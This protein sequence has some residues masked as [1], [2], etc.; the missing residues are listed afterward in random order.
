[1]GF[2]TTDG[3]M[4]HLRNDK[5]IRIAGSL[6]KRQLSNIGYFHG[7]KGYRF[8]KRASNPIP[9]DSFKDIYNTVQFD[10]KIKSIIYPELMFIETA[11]K[12]RSIESIV[13]S[14]NSEDIQVILDK[15]I[16]SYKNSPA[17]ISTKLKREK[18][19]AKME[20]QSTIQRIILDAYRHNNPQITHFID[21]PSR[22]GVPLWALV[23][24]MTLGN[25]GKL[26]SCLTFNVRK[27]ISIKMNMRSSMD[28]NCEFLYKF[29]WLLKDL[30]NAVAHNSPVF[31]TRFR[32][33]DPSRA[34]KGYLASQTH[35]PF[36]KFDNIGDYIILI[37]F[38]L[39]ILGSSKTHIKSFLRS[40]KSACQLYEKSVAHNV[41]YRV[42]PH[43][44]YSR[45][46]IVAKNI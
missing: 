5:A 26:L 42:L 35:L 15:L 41:S 33:F 45:I 18:Q 6:E 40:Y 31:D 2:K 12:S 23:E 44:I 32:K 19:Q 17:N 39:K 4:R 10:S 30:R 46:S 43:G 37:A 36:V 8:F 1:M 25:F 13:L 3:L 21:S 14:A 27:E 38:I 29:V 24:V 28:T 11:I 20:L 7:Y 34:M 9:F 22:K 16:E